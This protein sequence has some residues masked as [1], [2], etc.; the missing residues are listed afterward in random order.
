MGRARRPAR[1]AGPRGG[2][3][4]RRP[5]PTPRDDQARGA[6]ALGG[7]ILELRLDPT[8]PLAY[9]YRDSVPVFKSGS[10]VFRPDSTNSGIDVG[11]YAES[12][13]LSG[14][15]SRAVRERLSGAAGL[16]AARLGRGR[17]VL[18][19]FNPAFRAFWYGTDG[20]L[21]NA[22]YLGQTF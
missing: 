14:Y 3:R 2:A 15:A 22:V 7:S 9:G 21:L 6:Q 11:R 10:A 8:H 17:V 18:M 5:T 1:R 4:T 13:V 12:P 19:D 20:L 16:R